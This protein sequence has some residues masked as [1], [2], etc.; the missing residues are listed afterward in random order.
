METCLIVYL[1][2]NK[3]IVITV[4]NI[5]PHQK[6]NNIKNDHQFPRE[7]THSCYRGGNQGLEL[8]EEG[9]GWSLTCPLSSRQ[10]H[11]FRWP[12]VSGSGHLFPVHTLHFPIKVGW[13]LKPAL[14]SSHKCQIL[15]NPEG[16]T[17]TYQIPE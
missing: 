14:H 16:W 10:N 8:K 11:D 3:V 1:A 4:E 9:L 12:L 2:L 6:H 7:N 15:K 5:R 17:S 13:I